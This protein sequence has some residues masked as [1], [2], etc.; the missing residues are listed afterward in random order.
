MTPLETKIRRRIGLSGPITIAEYWSLC[1]FD[2]DHGYYTTREPIGA[3]GD[4]ITAPE[5]SQ[6]FGEM[7][8]AWWLATVRENSIEPALVEIGPGRGT[9][10]ADMLRT[11]DKLAP[12]QRQS[13]QVHMVEVSPRLTA[14]QEDTLENSGFKI[15]WHQTIAT[16]PGIPL[17]VIANELFDAIPVRQLIKN[18]S[19]WHEQAVT[20]NENGALGLTALPIS[21]A[22]AILP[23]AHETRPDGAVFEYAPAR[24]ALMQDLALKIAAQGGFGLFIDYGHAVPGFGDTL[25][26]MKNHAFA[27]VLETPGQ[28][29]ITSH[30]DFA[31]LAAAVSGAGLSTSEITGQGEF[32]ARLGIVERSKQLAASQPQLRDSLETALERLVSPQ[33]MGSLFKVLGIASKPLALPAL[34]MAG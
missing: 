3:A 22:P 12:R 24:E 14:V 11:I 18:A 2:P 4:F 31:S 9:L 8:A 6:M 26:A 25:Q 34:Q 28:A 20:L 32:L 30:V 21:I 16:L 10:M 13:L 15:T 19:S 7:L 1:L 29:D 5:V 23:Q 27:N 33:Q 17:G